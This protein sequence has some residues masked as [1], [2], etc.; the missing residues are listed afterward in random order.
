MADGT[1]AALLA[2]TGAGSAALSDVASQHPR[3][4]RRLCAVETMRWW[5]E[6]APDEVAAGAGQ[7]EARH[8]A[9][10]Q[11][12]HCVIP[13]WWGGEG[14]GGGWAE[15]ERGCPSVASKCIV[16]LSCHHPARGC[17]ASSSLAPSPLQFLPQQPELQTTHHE[18]SDRLPQALYRPEAWHVSP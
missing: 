8:D 12:G 7:W 1:M 3:H 11:R 13:R 2:W 14:P 5:S 15:H 10:M 16:L 4:G 18:R 6:A 9:A 17:N